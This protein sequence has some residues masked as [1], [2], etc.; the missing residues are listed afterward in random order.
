MEF[1]IILSDREISLDLAL[2][3]TLAL[4]VIVLLAV[5]FW[6]FMTCQNGGLLP[7]AYRTA[8][9]HIVRLSEICIPSKYTI[10]PEFSMQEI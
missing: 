6:I 8:T 1:K 4:F 9:L 10:I 7:G 2:Y 5:F 3:T